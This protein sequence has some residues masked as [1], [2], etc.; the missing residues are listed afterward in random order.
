MYMKFN[1]VILSLNTYIFWCNV[2]YIGQLWFQWN[3]IKIF[4]ICSYLSF[5]GTNIKNSSTFK[6]GNHIYSRV[7]VVH[8]STFSMFFRLTAFILIYRSQTLQKFHISSFP[9]FQPSSVPPSS[10]PCFHLSIFSPLTIQK[11]IFKKV[12]YIYIRFLI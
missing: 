10:N 1:I 8:K 6:L 12:F 11:Y 5:K 2:V 9:R 3:L 4:Q 7:T